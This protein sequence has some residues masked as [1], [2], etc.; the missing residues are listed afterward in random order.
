MNISDSFRKT[1]VDEFR[2]AAKKMKEETEA[3]RKI[4]FFS[5]TYGIVFRVFNLEFDPTLVFIHNVLQTTY[6]N[7]DNILHRIARREE[8]VIQIPDRVLENLAEAIEELSDEIERDGDVAQCLQKISNIGYVGTGNG[9]YL[10]QKG[11]LR[12]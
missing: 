9:Y 1:I 2:Y 11:T 6:A 5:A 7:I 8:T 4:Y 10:Y 3:F 12:I